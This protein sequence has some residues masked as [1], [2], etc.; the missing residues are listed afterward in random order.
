MPAYYATAPGKIILFGEHAVVYGHPAIAV[1]VLQVRAKATVSFELKSAPG[2][3]TLRA[4]DIGL[5]T[6]LSDLPEDHP[7]AA[8]IWKA[9]TAMN[10]DH[11]PACTIQVSSNIPIAGGMGSSAAVSVAILRAFSASVGHPLSDEQV[12]KLA[13]EV[14]VIHHGYPSGIDNSAITYAMP[15]YFE[16]GKTI[17][18]LQ[19][20]HPFTL[21]IGDTGVRSPTA[22]VVNDVH[23]AWK[24]AG[25]G[26]ESLFNNVGAIVALARE[27][28]ETGTI[29]SLG[30]LMH[31]NHLLLQKMGVS[32]PEL[33][34]LVDAARSAG[35]L[36]AKLSGAGRG[37]N[38]IA[39]VTPESS[40]EI[41]RALL[42]AGAIR[43][44]TT[45]I[46]AA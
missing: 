43:T 21:V 44:I 35:A 7:L 25:K 18:I 28:I 16:K 40:D 5:E 8:V 41:A 31:E 19:V 39:L 46:R 13:Y 20:K 3:V 26:Y 12:S 45:E 17:E 14:E 32:S 6:S 2:K 23:E 15:V 24:K 1:P 33:D 42:D 22:K 30:P 38:M 36:G 9:A 10:L 29:D 27:A 37:G 4:P 11:I 34:G